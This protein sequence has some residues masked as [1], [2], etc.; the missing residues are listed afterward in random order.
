MYHAVSGVATAGAAAGAGLAFSG[1]NLAYDICAAF[2][3][4]AA[5]LALTRIVP[6]VPSQPLMFRGAAGRYGWALDDPHR[7][8][9][10]IERPGSGYC[11][12]PRRRRG[13][14]W[15]LALGGCTRAHR[16]SSGATTKPVAEGL[17]STSLRLTP[18]TWRDNEHN[19]RC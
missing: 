17:H 2:A 4:L 8:H 16:R 14:G 7:P 3:L 9:L 1:L 15:Q 10:L 12:V 11:L 5:G 18:D 6:R 19:K 13:E